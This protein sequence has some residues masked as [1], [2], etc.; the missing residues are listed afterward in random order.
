V[1]LGEV[2]HKIFIK[3]IYVLDAYRVGGWVALGVMSVCCSH[4][5]GVYS[6]GGPSMGDCYR[7]S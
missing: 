2:F 1:V 5:D 4:L 6:C 3:N 7:C